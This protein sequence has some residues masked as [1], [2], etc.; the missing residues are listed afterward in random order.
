[1][2]SFQATPDKGKHAGKET[3]IGEIKD[4]VGIVV[5]HYHY[6][7]GRCNTCGH[8]SISQPGWSPQRMHSA[9]AVMYIAENLD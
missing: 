8:G 2:A 1:M 9:T 3:D 6:L 7:A 5:I 4:E